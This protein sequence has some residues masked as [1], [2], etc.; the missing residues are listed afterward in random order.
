MSAFGKDTPS[1]QEVDQ[2]MMVM[3]DY[4]PR[5]WWNVY[6][7]SIQAGFPPREAFAL[8][9]TYILSQNPNGIVLPRGNGPGSDVP[10]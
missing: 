3:R 4:H 7:G 8:L 9:Q 1:E 10:E 6:Q 5:A 2:I